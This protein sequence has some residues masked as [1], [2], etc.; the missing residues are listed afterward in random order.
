MLL[1]IPWIVVYTEK[2]YRILGYDYTVCTAQW[3]SAKHHKLFSVLVIFL[4]RYILP[5]IVIAS[6]YFVIGARVWR[7]K[8]RGVQGAARKSINKRRA[9]IVS[10]LV[11]VVV[12]FFVSWL[13]L[14]ALE[15]WTL[16]GPKFTRQQK[17][18][19]KL[20]LVPLAQWLGASNS[21][22]NPFIYVIFSK[23]IRAS[24]FAV[25]RSKTCCSDIVVA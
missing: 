16:F 23:K 14:Y 10:M 12:I 18:L 22:V 24:I 11:V 7:R 9:R 21:C 4:T 19:F 6:F 2:T 17:R 5:L 8:V 1:F 15:M 3:P 13:P 20:Y 25:L